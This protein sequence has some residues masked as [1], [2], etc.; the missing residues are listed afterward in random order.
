M[1][2]HSGTGNGCAEPAADSIYELLKACA[3]Q[4]PE[5]IAIVA[6]GRAALTYERL[7]HQAE[8]MVG[9]L[10]AVGVGRND[11]VA[12]VLPNG[13]EMAVSFL[14]VACGATCAPLNP[15]YKAQEFDFYLS[16]L[17]VRALIV[18]SNLDSPVR[19]I[20]G[21]RRVPILELTPTVQ[22]PAGVFEVRGG[23]QKAGT[24]LDFAPPDDTALVLH[25][26]GTTSRPKMVPLTQANICSSGRH[27]AS[28]LALTG[29]D[30]CLN[31]MPLFHIHGLMAAVIASLTAR[32]SIVCTPGFAPESFF[33]W[34]D[35]FKPTWYTAVPTIHQAVLAHA[36]PNQAIIARRP[37]RF[38]R[39]SSAALPRP[40]LRKLEDIFQTQ[41]IEAYGMTE[42][43]HQMTSNPLVP[44]PRKP[45]SVGIAAGPDVAIMDEAGSMLPVGKVGEV[46]IRGPNVTRGYLN[47]PQSNR[48]AFTNGWFRTGDQGR[49]DDEGYL[50]LTG[51]LKEIIN[52]GGEKVAPLEVDDV[53]SQHPAVAQAITF[54]VPHPTLGEDVAAAV[55]LR[56]HA[57]VT[58]RDIQEFAARHLADHK[59]PK[60]LLFVDAIP[61]GPT[62]KLQRIGLAEH[63]ASQ[64]A[65]RLKNSFVAPA[66]AVEK[67]LAAIW[68]RLLDTES[69]G[70]HDDF[71]V[72]GGDSLALATMLAE[73]KSR[74]CTEIPV[75]S[76]LQ[77]PTVDTLAQRI[78][79]SE[80]ARL[81]TNTGK[82]THAS[83]MI[84]DSVLTGIKNRVLQLL[85][86]HAPGFK[87]LRVWLHRLRGVSIGKNVSI[88]L[89]VLIE[90]AYPR[91]VSIGNNVTIG[92]RAVIIGHLRDST[93]QARATR[94]PTVRIEDD[95][96][97]GPGVIILPN[98][99]I[100]KG[101]V[102]SAGSVVSR[103]VPPNTMVRGNPAEPIAHCGAS[104]G[105]GVSYEEFLRRLSPIKEHRPSQ[106]RR[107]T[108][109]G[110]VNMNTMDQMS[111]DKSGVA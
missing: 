97:I 11:R 87:T 63:F 101:A 90:T 19:E 18:A 42:A 79:G 51:R 96:Y 67:E 46:V 75:D 5:A 84:R 54:G 44:L 108:S 6:P 91:L 16:D 80:S 57:E 73:V 28:T 27:I 14:G 83:R 47:N 98:V 94:Q 60:Q 85:A 69:I 22:A 58:E 53:L 89:S 103:S 12:V 86:L 56:D 2:V 37:M 50:F 41:V 9:A 99:V 1:V 33:E 30:R 100:G 13:P 36:S 93:T 21:I 71:H 66:S 59:V 62:G 102:V 34:L 109:S 32:A 20:A 40:V 24:S 92:M 7:L 72:L 104:L 31:V 81:Q 82:V 78:Q 8:I 77:C 95:V 76:F 105:G 43:A 65:D 111:Y 48:S 106:Q 25:T 61:K 35:D 23:R 88:G 38:I 3:S 70:V 49:F 110:V 4:Y 74:F 52:R 45:G 55:V 15:S 17:N 29:E 68:G 39:S 107:H 64:L 26:S 10:R